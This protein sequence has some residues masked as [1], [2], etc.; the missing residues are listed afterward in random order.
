MNIQEIKEVLYADGK[1]E[2]DF[3]HNETKNM[4]ECGVWDEMGW[5]ID[6]SLYSGNA[7][8]D[9]A[10][11][12]DNIF[13]CE[14]GKEDF[15]IN[16][17]SNELRILKEILKEPVGDDEWTEIRKT[18]KAAIQSVLDRLSIRNEE[19]LPTNSILKYDTSKINLTRRYNRLLRYTEAGDNII[20]PEDF[21]V[22]GTIEEIMSDRYKEDNK[23]IYYVIERMIDYVYNVD[24][25]D[26]GN[27][28]I[29]DNWT[30]DT[31][32]SANFLSMS[33]REFIAECDSF[34]THLRIFE[35]IQELNERVHE[36]EDYD[37]NIFKP[38]KALGEY[39]SSNQAYKKLK[40][41]ND[42][43]ISTFSAIPY[44]WEDYYELENDG[45]YLWEYVEIGHDEVV[46][47]WEAIEMEL[48]VYKKI[49]TVA[50]DIAN[51]EG[52]K[53]LSNELNEINHN[54][55]PD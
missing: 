19:D 22:D 54:L 15:Y 25:S 46:N 28:D 9:I 16:K 43:I 23:S 14:V 11:E 20:I 34:F 55:K 5:E 29:I 7:K 6:D 18:R 3:F 32:G 41:I 26:I 45:E 21:T 47:D 44:D 35:I 10:N 12:V 30:M 36:F 17:Y 51:F 27:E 24:I 52:C 53:K 49:N 13:S 8:V 37:G 39:L 42:R 40:E 50:A 4:K 38:D 2:L 1:E 33:L 31:I 48:F